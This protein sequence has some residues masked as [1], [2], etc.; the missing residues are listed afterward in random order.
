MTDAAIINRS[1]NSLVNAF[2]AH[3]FS[4]ADAK[5]AAMTTLIKDMMD[6]G[7]RVDVAF[8]AVIGEGSY[9]RLAGDLYG[10]LRAA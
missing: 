9:E 3:G 5:N 7:V 8:D 10:A 6:H 1:L 4:L 2:I